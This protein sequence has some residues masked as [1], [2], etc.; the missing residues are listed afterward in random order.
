[1]EGPPPPIDEA[2]DAVLLGLWRV[3]ALQF[4]KPTR[5]L[6]DAFEIEQARIENQVERN[7]PVGRLGKRRRLDGRQQ[8]DGAEV[9]CDARLCEPQ[10]AVLAHARLAETTA[11][12]ASESSRKMAIAGSTTADAACPFQ[13][14][15]VYGPPARR[16]TEDSIPRGSRRPK[17][18]SGSRRYQPSSAPATRPWCRDSTIP[19][20]RPAIGAGRRRRMRRSRRYAKPST[21]LLR[22]RPQSG[23]HPG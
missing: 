8:L 21:G 13:S 20:R 9:C 15:R 18:A 6:L 4:L 7:P 10:D 12:A 1:M 23:R 5:R 3:T 2:A 19:R 14:P 17:R 16:A 11:R 22:Y